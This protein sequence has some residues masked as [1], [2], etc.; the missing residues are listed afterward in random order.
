MKKRRIL[1]LFGFATIKKKVVQ[2]EASNKIKGLRKPQK[3]THKPV[4]MH[5]HC[6]ISLTSG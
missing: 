2:L 4:N 6:L 1:C 5:Q 3:Q